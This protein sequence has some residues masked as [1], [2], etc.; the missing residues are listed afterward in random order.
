MVHVHIT[1]NDDGLVVRTIPFVVII[2]QHLRITAIYDAH[3][4]DG[5]TLAIL[6]AG[7][8]A[9]EEFLLDALHGTF[10]QLPFLMDDAALL[11]N[12]LAF[13]REAVRPV[14]QHEYAGVESGHALR[15]HVADAIHG[16]VDGS[17]GIQVA[18]EVNT[19][20]TGEVEQCRVGE[21]LRTVEGHVLQEVSQSALVLVLL[22]GTHALCDVEVGHVLGP[23]VLADIVGQTVVQLT[24]S[25]VFVNWNR[26]HLHLLCHHHGHAAHEQSGHHQNSFH[27]HY[28]SFL[29]YSLYAPP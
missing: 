17:V 6:R 4:S 12:L 27:F 3:Q 2:A 18:T 14:F 20:A 21:M 28:L 15:G 25:H 13:Q 29:D 24:D 22:N 1:D 11:L 8:Q 26:R 9:G 7:I 23:V 19:N 10:T 16:L 5:Q